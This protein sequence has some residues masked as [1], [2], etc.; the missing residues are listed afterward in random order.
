MSLQDL[1][2]I[3]EFVAA[4]GVIVS[5]IYLAV[6]I[7]QNTRTVRAAAFQQV[8]DS[9]A[10]FT[11]SLSRDRELIEI[12]IKGNADFD[13]LDEVERT[14]FDF[15][16]ISFFRRAENVVVQTEYGTLSADTWT[17]FRETLKSSLRAPGL[18]E[19][20]SHRRQRFHP[21]FQKFMREQILA[22][23]D[24]ES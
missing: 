18:F 23:S 22:S 7:R 12:V 3:G 13:S 2:N 16:F 15:A 24:E 5:L 14:R 19:W 6:Q 17:G 1:G 8:V 9:L 21:S 11:S 4:I 20:W 10:D